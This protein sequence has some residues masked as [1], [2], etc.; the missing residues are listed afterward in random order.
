MEIETGDRAGM[1]CVKKACLLAATG[2]PTV[3]LIQFSAQSDHTQLWPTLSQIM[4]DGR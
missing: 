3:L 4:R 2:S 1:E